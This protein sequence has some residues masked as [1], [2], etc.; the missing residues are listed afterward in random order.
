MILSE[1]SLQLLKDYIKQLD[2]EVSNLYHSLESELPENQ[3]KVY[4][5]LI[6][7]LFYI[8]GQINEEM[9]FL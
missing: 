1:H 8:I 4:E 6:D 5:K 2:G 3:W 9:Y 7:R